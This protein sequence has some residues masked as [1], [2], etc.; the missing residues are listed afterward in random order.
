MNRIVRIDKFSNFGIKKFSTKS[1]Q[2]TPN[3]LMNN[4][5][6]PAVKIVEPFRCLGRYFDYEMTNKQHQLDA[7]ATVTELLLQT[8]L[9]NIHPKYKFLLY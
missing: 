3:L 7:K 8:D 2:F 6:I 4:Q 5:S 1:L 9:L